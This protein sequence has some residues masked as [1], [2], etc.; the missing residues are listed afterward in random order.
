MAIPSVGGD[1]LKGGV[2]AGHMQKAAKRAVVHPSMIK[3][4]PDALPKNNDFMAPIATLVSNYAEKKLNRV[5]KEEK[6]S[7]LRRKIHEL[8]PSPP[9][10]HSSDDNDIPSNKK[11]NRRLH[12]SKKNRKKSGLYTSSLHD[13]VWRVTSSDKSKEIDDSLSSSNFD[14]KKN[15]RATRLKVSRPVQKSFLKAVDYRTYRLKNKSK[16]YNSKIASIVARW[17]KKFEILTEK[18]GFW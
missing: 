8:P 11:K 15:D 16:R 7:G 13:D 14:D 5:K 18:E 17:M 6:C 12:R 4:V 1:V 10:S 2:V 9:T 3:A